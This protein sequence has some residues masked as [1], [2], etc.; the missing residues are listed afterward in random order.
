MSGPFADIEI[1]GD[2]RAAVLLNGTTPDFFVGHVD[3]FNWNWIWHQRLLVKPGSY[4][5]T[6]TRNGN[7]IWSGPV[8]A[9]AG[10]QVTVYLDQNGK[11][12]TK[13]WKQ[14]TRSARFRAFRPESPARPFPSRR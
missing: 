10:E 5:L 2:P 9:N 3:E 14:S 4:Q 11:M 8:M 13:P 6:V 1:K 7:T 12:K